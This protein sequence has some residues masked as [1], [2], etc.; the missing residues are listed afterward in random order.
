LA[1]ISQNERLWSFRF[2]LS[3]NFDESF[4]RLLASIKT[5]DRPWRLFDALRDVAGIV[6]SFITNP[7]GTSRDGLFEPMQV[8]GD[9]D[10][11]HARALIADRL[12]SSPRC[13]RPASARRLALFSPR[14][15]LLAYNRNRFPETEIAP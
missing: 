8:F 12:R 14:I 10:S 3:D 7:L 9:N 6:Q 11:L 5:G 15:C 1:A 4:P 2:R 13:P